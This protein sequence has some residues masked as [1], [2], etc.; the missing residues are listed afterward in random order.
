MSAG[1]D[2]GTVDP[3]AAAQRVCA[4]FETLS[5]PAVADLG[6]IYAPDASFRDPFN[7]VRGLPAIQCV[8]AA[9]FEHLI[10][11]RFIVA[12][13]IADERGAFLVW[14]MTYRIRKLQ[15]AR[16]RTIHGS[17]HLRFDRSGRIEYH[18]DYWDAA[19]ELYA[20][21]PLIGPVIRYLQKKLG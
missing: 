11:P 10:E 1:L 12:D 19:E 18:R 5:A 4:F 20:T 21:L 6:A 8:Y 9:M 16:V 3:R 2:M 15:P 14:N 13:T 7:D 17:S